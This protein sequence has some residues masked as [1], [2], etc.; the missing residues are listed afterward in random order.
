MQHLAAQP[1]I[2]LLLIVYLDETSGGSSIGSVLV[3]MHS[4]LHA[5]QSYTLQCWSIHLFKLS[6]Q[7]IVNH[8]LIAMSYH[9]PSDGTT[10]TTITGSSL[11]GQ[12]TL[13]EVDVARCRV[14]V[15]TQGAPQFRSAISTPPETFVAATRRP[16]RVQAIRWAPQVSAGSMKM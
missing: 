9:T 12:V 8:L 1:V 4:M 16:S 10:P 6:K 5:V 14:Q 2:D 3:V 15:H 13:G 7:T 11:T